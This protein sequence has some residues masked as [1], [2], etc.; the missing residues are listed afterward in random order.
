M[1]MV[2]ASIQMFAEYPKLKKMALMVIAH[3]STSEEIGFLR[4]IF[5]LY[6]KSHHGMVTL[7]DFCAALE[8]YK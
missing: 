4:Q 3:K 6:D 7:E 8:G 1:D 5:N 2:Q